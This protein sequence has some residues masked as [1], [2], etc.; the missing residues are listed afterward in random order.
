MTLAD[1]QALIGDAEAYSGNS[2]GGA[3]DR[4]ETARSSSTSSAPPDR[5]SSHDR[6]CM[7]IRGNT[8]T[9]PSRIAAD[10]SGQVLSEMP[11]RT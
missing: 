3:D 9:A 8:I 10:T 1:A 7:Y 11:F 4:P 2:S 5:T 6:S